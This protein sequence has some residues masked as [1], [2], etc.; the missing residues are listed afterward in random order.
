MMKSES[1][2]PAGDEVT[3]SVGS[4]ENLLADT[5]ALLIDRKL[6]R[7]IDLDK[8]AQYTFYLGIRDYVKTEEEARFRILVGSESYVKNEA[9]RLLNIPTQA[10][11]HQNYPNPFNPSTI[12]R[13]D[14]A[15][16]GQV[17][18]RVYDVSGALVKVLVSRYRETGRYEVGWDADNNR[19]EPISSGIY[20][21]R[22]TAPGYSKTRKMVLVR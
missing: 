21:Y 10:A 19:G 1:M 11:L 12:I 5:K 9:A 4:L 2:E 20:F 22:L 16:P 6:D 14:V 15:D 18:L 13:Y 7:K 8:D 3:I 17:D